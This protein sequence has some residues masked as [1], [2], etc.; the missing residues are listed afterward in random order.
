[1]MLAHML[2]FCEIAEA[3]PASEFWIFLC[4]HWSHVEWR[5]MALHDLIQPGFSFLVGTALTLRRFAIAAVVCLA[6]GYALDAT[7][8]CPNV[9][10]IWTPAWVLVSGG[11]CFAVLGLLHAVCD[12]AGYRLWAFPLVVFG[13]N[14]IVAY[15]MEWFM[16][17]F[18][19]ENLDRHLGSDW[20]ESIVG[21]VYSPLLAGETTLLVIWLI[22]L[23]MH[24]RKI[25]V[26]I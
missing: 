12:R 22:L 10:R 13:M 24:Q 4:F 18:I 9:K 21:P 15:V 26:K 5:G 19:L 20:A 11:W 7:G 25:Y 23:W 6:C 1:M 17:G 3:K 8:V 14:S 16:P 2:G